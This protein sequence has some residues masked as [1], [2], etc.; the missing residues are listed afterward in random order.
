MSSEFLWKLM[1]IKPESYR[2]NNMVVLYPTIISMNL[3]LIH[4][5]LF[6]E[7]GLI[8]GLSLLIISALN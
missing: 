6:P 7:V 8:I 2:I 5:I 3:S 4:N 1:S